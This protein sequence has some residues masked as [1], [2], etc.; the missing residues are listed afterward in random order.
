M[1]VAAFAP[2]AEA[3]QACAVLLLFVAVLEEIFVAD[4]FLILDLNIFSFFSSFNWTF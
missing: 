2:G 4:L 3:A 1:G